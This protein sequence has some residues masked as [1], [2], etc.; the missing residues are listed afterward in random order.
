MN[1]TICTDSNQS[2]IMTATNFLHQYPLFTVPKS[3][4]RL[5]LEKELNEVKEELALLKLQK[6]IYE[7]RKD[8][9]QIKDEIGHLIC[10]NCKTNKTDITQVLDPCG[11][12]ILCRS[13]LDT[14]D[15]CPKCSVKINSIITLAPMGSYM[16][17]ASV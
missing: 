17:P 16:S 3:K 1:R 10:F 4:E 7:T 11:H 9:H 8:I 13:C 2:Y 12:R 15:V 14:L 6:D 5:A